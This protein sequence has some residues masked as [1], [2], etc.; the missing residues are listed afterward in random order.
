MSS[1]FHYG[2][3]KT[4]PSLKD[5]TANIFGLNSTMVRLKLREFSMKRYE[6]FRLNSTMVRLKPR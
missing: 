2:S 3:I 1:Q 4:L 5:F 6:W